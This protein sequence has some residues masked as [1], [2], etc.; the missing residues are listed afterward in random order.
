[1]GFIATHLCVVSLFGS[2]NSPVLSFSVLTFIHRFSTRR[3][4]MVIPFSQVARMASMLPSSQSICKVFVNITAWCALFGIL[5][6]PAIESYAK[7]PLGFIENR[8][9]IEEKV[10]YYSQ[11]PGAIVYFTKQE[12]VFVF[13]RRLVQEDKRQPR[14]ISEHSG[15]PELALHDAAKRRCSVWIRFKQPNPLVKVAGQGEYT[16]RL[17]FF[18]GND[19]M[20]W[21]T[22]VRIYREIYYED[23]WPGIDLIFHF[24]DGKILY[25]AVLEA[26]VDS[27]RI[28]FSYEGAMCESSNEKKSC[29]LVTPLGEIKHSIPSAVNPKADISWTHAKKSKNYEMHSSSK[30]N[31]DALLWST[32]IGGSGEE[33]A[34]AITLDSSDQPI[35]TGRTEALG[36]PIS[37]GVYDSTY[38]GASDVYVA[39]FNA[40]GNTLLWSTFIGG[41]S[42]DEAYA[43][44]MDLTGNPIVSGRTGSSD[45]PT[46]P[47]AY[48]R[49][50]NGS[51]DIFVTKLNAE[52]NSILWSTFIGGGSGDQGWDLSLDAN[53]NV[54]ITGET[55]S[56]NFPTT[57]GAFDDTPGTDMR[58]AFVAKLDATGSTLLLGTYLGGDLDDYARGITVDAMGNYFITGSAYSPDFPTTPGAFDQ[59][60]NGTFDVFVSKL[61]ATGS[62]LL[63]STLMGGIAYDDGSAIVLDP[64]G[65]PVVTGGTSNSNFPTTSGAY[66][67]LFTGSHSRIFVTKLDTSGNTLVWSTFLGGFYGDF[68]RDMILDPA[69]NPILT[70]YTYSDD[71]P[72]TAGAYDRCLNGASDVIVAKLNSSGTALLWSS[73]LGGSSYEEGLGIA[74]NSL[75][76]P[77]MS[78]YTFSSDFST[79]PQA[80][81]PDYN[82]GLR[83]AFIASFDLLDGPADPPICSVSPTTLDFGI[84]A[85]GDST[86]RS[87]TIKNLGGDTLRGNLVESCGYYRIVAGQDD[88]N[89]ASPESV[90]VVVRFT[91]ET[92]G[93]FDC[94]VV[95]DS[96]MCADV[97]CTGIG[98]ESIPVMVQEFQ[99]RWMR[100]HAEITWTLAGIHRELVFR[101][102]RRKGPSGNFEKILDPE[103]IK[104]NDTY[105]FYDRNAQP[106]QIYHY[107]IEAILNN[108]FTTLFETTL[109]TP[110]S[111]LILYQNRPNPFNPATKL[112]FSLPERSNVIL[113][114]YNLEGKLLRTLINSYFP[115]GF[116]E[117]PWDGTDTSGNRVSSG[118]YMYRLKVRNTTLTRKMV[119]LK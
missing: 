94:W 117:L 54:V 43:I 5:S 62:M 50:R 20:H 48:D 109:N 116:H 115:A 22:G 36:F 99:S 52:G 9:Q 34:W 31:P 118:V 113:S 55:R 53:E 25:Q 46:T 98:D 64:A 59:S 30:N 110:A 88:F 114:I 10:H 74:L 2:A 26:G 28:Q 56:S 92:T 47:G 72:T 42:F 57:P 63:W 45:F 38:A 105:V 21:Q 100:N 24:E 29:V 35:I 95:V 78:G 79:T 108:Q 41:N 69:G 93:R 76:A 6:W 73:Y 3:L 11:V 13:S 1:M 90:I 106:G 65:Y 83:D 7:T 96:F 4:V 70:G 27:E 85:V 104:T 107:R 16:S 71:F 112:A 60:H 89:L 61:D 14:G 8:G 75:G 51:N 66:D 84:L 102:F 87:F 17:N 67:S 18:R 39:K 91:P 81:D 119:L 82:G 101:I 103:I 49:S 77:V 32:F 23:I 33:Y 12:I 97:F 37:P 44:T 58:D 111:E 19:R 80:Y 86:D 68:S 15:L 40:A